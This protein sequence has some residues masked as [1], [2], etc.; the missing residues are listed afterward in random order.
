MQHSE[1]SGEDQLNKLENASRELASV[2]RALAAESD[3]KNKLVVAKSGAKLL[4]RPDFVWYELLL[5]FATMGNSRGAEGLMRTPA[6]Y[7]RVT[8]PSLLKKRSSVGSFPKSLVNAVT[9]RSMYSSMRSG[10]GALSSNCLIAS[11]TLPLALI[12]L[13]KS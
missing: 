6:N 10:V 3:V 8:F 1:R 5:S 12:A 2:I 13:T 4:K 9:G 7:R 11:S